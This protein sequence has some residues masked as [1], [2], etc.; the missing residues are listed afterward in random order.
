MVRNIR[1]KVAHTYCFPR[2][3]VL[4][5][6]DKLLSVLERH[7]DCSN[8]VIYLGSN[9]VSQQQSEILCADFQLLISAQKDPW[10]CVLIS[11]P[12]PSLGWDCGRFSHLL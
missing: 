1:A 8:L 11:G 5:I 6:R 4:D 12:I 7:P 9:D 3:R 10:K 2:A